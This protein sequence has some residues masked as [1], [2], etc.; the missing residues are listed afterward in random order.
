M[1]SAVNKASISDLDMD[2]EDANGLYNDEADT[3]DGGTA[4]FSEWTSL[5]KF[6]RF[7]L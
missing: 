2:P 3:T 1:A 6:I 4:S 5:I 7:L